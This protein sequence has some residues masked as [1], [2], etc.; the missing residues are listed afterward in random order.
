MNST[1]LPQGTPDL[2]GIPQAE[3]SNAE[4]QLLS[5]QALPPPERSWLRLGQARPGSA[6]E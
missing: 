1:A 4:Q 2:A 5:N 3:S 6:G